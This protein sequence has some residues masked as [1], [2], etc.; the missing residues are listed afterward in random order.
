MEQRTGTPVKHRCV[1]HLYALSALRAIP[2]HLP[3]YSIIINYHCSVHH[4]HLL[5]QYIFSPINAVFSPINLILSPRKVIFPPI[6]L[7][8]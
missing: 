7:I 6:N 8:I 1:T 2:R 5:I 4:Q 3:F